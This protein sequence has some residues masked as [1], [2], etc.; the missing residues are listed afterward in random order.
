MTPCDDSVCM[1][2]DEF[3]DALLGYLHKESLLQRYA[4]RRAERSALS[5]LDW[6][7]ISE[8][9]AENAELL[10]RAWK[11]RNRRETKR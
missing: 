5:R 2:S 4:H 6:D 10:Q 1:I 3:F 7:T 9:R 8:A 11:L